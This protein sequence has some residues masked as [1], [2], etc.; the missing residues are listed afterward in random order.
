M[1]LFKKLL[2]IQ[3]AIE[4]LGKDGVGDKYQYVTGNKLLGAVRPLMDKHGVLLISEITEA[5]YTRQDYQTKN[6][7]KS[8]MF[9]ALKMRFTWVDA[10]TGETLPCAWAAC[11]M[12]NWDKGAGSAATYAERYFIMKFFHIATDEDDVDSVKSPEEQ[13]S[14]DKAIAYINGLKTT[15][16]LD[17]AWR[18]YEAYWKGNR[19]IKTAFNKR[20]QEIANGTRTQ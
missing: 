12:N 6:G 4:G 9:C 14:D 16:D 15:Q 20:K 2:E 11:G 18:Q 8:E 7:G 1:A 17:A 3:K 5:E 13:M 19:A 10:D